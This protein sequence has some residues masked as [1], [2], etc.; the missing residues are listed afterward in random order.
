M[1]KCRLLRLAAIEAISAIQSTK[2]L[3]SSSA[4]TN[5][6][7]KKTRHTVIINCPEDLELDSYPGTFAQIITNF[8]INSLI[9]GFEDQDQGNIVIHVT[10]EHGI[11]LIRYSDNGKGMTEEERSQIFEPFYTT[12][13][14]QGGSGLGLHI[15][16]NLVTKRLQGNIVCESTP[17]VG[18]TF[19]IQ[20][21]LEGTIT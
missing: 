6:K 17:D 19:I 15:V 10:R 16:Y 1:R 3:T 5:P 4:Q 7:L 20:I 11:L 13:H 12:K 14:G 8:V 9:H 2:S 18:T 21:P